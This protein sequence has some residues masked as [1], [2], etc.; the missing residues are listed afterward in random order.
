MAGAGYRTFTAGAIL[1]AA[2]VQNYLQDQVVQVYAD[3]SARTTAL[4]TA[5]AEGM[6]SYLS[7]DNSLQ[8]YTGSSWVDIPVGDF[9]SQTNGVVTTAT[10]GSAVVRNITISTAVPSGGSDGDVWLVYTP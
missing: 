4:G 10:A 9:V 2:Q 3:A 7:T 6:V 8:V 1:T 5:V